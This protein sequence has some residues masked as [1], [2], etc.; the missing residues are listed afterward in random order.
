MKKLKLTV[1]TL[2]LMLVLTFSVG[3]YDFYLVNDYEE[4]LTEEQFNT[5]ETK[6]TDI[7]EKY[8]V[9]VHVTTVESFDEKSAMEFA[10]DFYDYSGLGYGENCDGLMLLVSKNEGE[11][12]ITTTGY[13]IT[14]F[15]DA[16]LDYIEEAFVPYLSDGDF[17]S[18]F[19]TFG[20]KCDEFLAQ[21][22]TGDP[23]DTHN[24][25]KGEFPYATYGAI[26][27]VAGLIIAAIITGG[28]KGKLKTV[29]KAT[30]AADYV[31]P[32]SIVVDERYDRFLY[33]T[34]DRE[35]K[36]SSSGGSSTHT[37]SSGTEHGGS[38]G[39]F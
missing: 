13:G 24:L 14:A 10:D 31:R 18:A 22:K 33:R 3:A 12:W 7:S 32:G 34:V 26:A 6:L 23:Y 29:V 37:G 20:T 9:A 30:E 27:V 5:L 2:C 17:Y 21:A 38:G 8:Q 35:K 16:G 19:D 11:W 39:K 36:E 28:M 25:P 4:L 15:T 1:L